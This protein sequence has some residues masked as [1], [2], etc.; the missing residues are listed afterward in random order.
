[1]NSLH[2]EYQIQHFIKNNNKNK[3]VVI[4]SVT[5]KPRTIILEESQQLMFAVELAK[6]GYDVLIEE[7]KAVIEQLQE[8]YGKLFSYKERK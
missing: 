1:M 8:S 2:L 5:Y 7:T 6:Q 3:Q 4:N